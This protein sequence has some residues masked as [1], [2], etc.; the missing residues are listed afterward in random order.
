MEA[1]VAV[2]A[3]NPEPALKQLLPVSITIVT[4]TDASLGLFYFLCLA[5][6]CPAPRAYKFSGF[7]IASACGLDTLINSHTR[8]TV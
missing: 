8:N 7:R 1:C 5:S 2:Y 3:L 6:H 4:L